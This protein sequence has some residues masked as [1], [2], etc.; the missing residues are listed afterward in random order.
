MV[1]K[2]WSDAQRQY[3]IGYCSSSSSCSFCPGAAPNAHAEPAL[4][5]LQLLIHTELNQGTDN[6]K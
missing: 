4:A 6:E 3:C 5:F 2:P 1:G